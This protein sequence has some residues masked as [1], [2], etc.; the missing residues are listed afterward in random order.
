M[1]RSCELVP[2]R[3]SSI[4]KST[5][6]APGGLIQNLAQ[7][8]DLGVEARDAALQRIGQADGSADGER[9]EAQPARA[10]RSAGLRQH[11]IDAER[12]QQRALAR[13]VGAADHQDAQFAAD[14][15]IVAHHLIF[16]NQ[17]MAERFAFE[18]RAARR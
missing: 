5:G 8:Q 12:A 13:H 3:N 6:S 2:C 1:R 17:G 9:R 16:G 11:G 15:D 14:A 18:P 10:H 7:A 4:R